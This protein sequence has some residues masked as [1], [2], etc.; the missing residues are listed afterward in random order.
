ME[1]PLCVSSEGAIPR[2]KGCTRP[3]GSMTL[4]RKRRCPTE[5]VDSGG[6]R[7]PNVALGRRLVVLSVG[8]LVLAALAFLFACAFSARGTGRHVLVISVDGMGSSYYMQP[9]DRLKTPSMR[10]LM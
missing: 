6:V 8:V 2:R 7:R 3:S 5:L 1:A 4:L 10:R 9:C